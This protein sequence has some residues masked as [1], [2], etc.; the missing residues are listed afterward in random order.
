MFPLQNVSVPWNSPAPLT[1]IFRFRSCYILLI[2][3]IWSLFM[4][5]DITLYNFFSLC[6]ITNSVSLKANFSGHASWGH[7]LAP[8]S[9]LWSQKLSCV[10]ITADFKCQL[11]I[12]HRS[13]VKMQIPSPKSFSC[14]QMF[15]CVLATLSHGITS[16]IGCE[17][18]LAGKFICCIS[19]WLWPQKVWCQLLLQ[20]WTTVNKK[21][22]NVIWTI[23]IETQNYLFL[24]VTFFGHKRV[25]SQEVEKFFPSCTHKMFITLYSLIASISTA[26]NSSDTKYCRHLTIS[27]LANHY[28]KLKHA[29]ACWPITNELQDSLKKT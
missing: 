28:P 7:V 19:S 23:G 8:Y 6:W 26:L 11:I 22:S 18:G 27:K 20:D 12:S 29:F 21:T 15:K 17:I 14:L 2:S 16:Y 24:D 5:R 25:G 1:Q 13:L 10:Y 9:A 4:G 3:P